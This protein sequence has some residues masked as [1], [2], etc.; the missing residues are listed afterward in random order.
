MMTLR[1]A[2]ALTLVVLATVM[3]IAGTG[4]IFTALTHHVLGAL[5]WG[6]PL[7]LAGLYW[8]GRALAQ[9]QRSAR[10]RRLLRAGARARG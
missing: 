3:G 5:A 2:G 7:A 4:L 10:R 6:L 1:A 9:S 8:C